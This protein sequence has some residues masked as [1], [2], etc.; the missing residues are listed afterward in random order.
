M[1]DPHDADEGEA[2]EECQKRRPLVLEL[3]AEI[4]GSRTRDFDLE[5]SGA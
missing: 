4:A 2:D 1:V 3:A 5:E